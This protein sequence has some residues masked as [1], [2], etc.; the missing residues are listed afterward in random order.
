MSRAR[1]G[2]RLPTVPQ[3]Y[4]RLFRALGPQ[5]WWPA[6]TTFE[7][8][9]GAILT[10]ATAWHNVE[11]AIHQ[12]KRAHGLSAKALAHL[13]TRRLQALIRP[14]GY[15]RQKAIRLQ[16]FSRWYLKSYCANSRRMFRTDA[17]TLRGQL[18]E[19]QGIG[20]ETADSILLYAGNQPVFV[21]D[22][23]TR[24]VF[25]RHQLLKGDEPY[26][27]IQQFVMDRLPEDPAML[28]EF[29]ALLVA[30]GKH[31]CHRHDPDCA[32]CPL[33]AFPHH[34]EVLEHG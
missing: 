27:T 6:D 9:V 21:V 33:G 34:P 32:H 24:R 30:A 1:R 28:N 12:L 15:F 18:L 16:T 17:W 8:M 22:A 5:H 14:A 3:L 10:Q 7:M 20:P 26:D 4:Q 23:Y 2:R 19:L 31:Y 13:R 29:H 11:R 25:A